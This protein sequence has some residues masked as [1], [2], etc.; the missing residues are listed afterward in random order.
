MN[1]SHIAQRTG[2]KCCVRI[3]EKDEAVRDERKRCTKEYFEC[4]VFA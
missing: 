2:R 4:V 1:E 3:R